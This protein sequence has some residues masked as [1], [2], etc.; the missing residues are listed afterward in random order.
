MVAS[1]IHPEA[2]T[3]STREN[4]A[5]GVLDPLELMFAS[6]AC[7]YAMRLTRLAALQQRLAE[8]E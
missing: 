4:L 8:W 6:S 5:Q 7:V 3:D 2:L 1:R